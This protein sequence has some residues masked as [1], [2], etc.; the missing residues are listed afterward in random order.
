MDSQ[1]SVT[2]DTPGTFDLLIDRQRRGHLEYSL[3]DDRTMVVLYVEVDPELRGHKLGERLVA[4]AVDWARANG[5]RIVPRCPYARAVMARTP[6][7]Q[8]VLR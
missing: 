5:R 2:H 6:E 8:D 1:L 7:Y 4:S 3:P